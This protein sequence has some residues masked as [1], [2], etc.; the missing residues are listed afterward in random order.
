MAMYGPRSEH[1]RSESGREE[2]LAPKA[3]SAGVRPSSPSG[4][5]SCRGARSAERRAAGVGP[6]GTIEERGERARRRAERALEDVT[7]RAMALAY[8]GRGREGIEEE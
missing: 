1:E 4:A 3:R 7:E 5:V 6:R 2:A 8:G